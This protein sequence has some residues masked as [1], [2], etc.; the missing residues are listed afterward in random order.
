MPSPGDLP[1]PGI[2][3]RYL[4]SPTLA[5]R[6]FTTGKVLYHLG[7]PDNDKYAYLNLPLFKVFVYIS[8]IFY[9]L[10][11]DFSS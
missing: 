1:N 10:T 9:N 4:K 8:L 6:F 11:V 2:E 3:P 5:G 7:S